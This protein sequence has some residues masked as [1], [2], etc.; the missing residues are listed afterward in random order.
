MSHS[1]PCALSA[2]SGGRFEPTRWT[3]ILRA[4]QDGAPGAAE[5]LENFARTYW[6]PIYR[7]IRWQGYKRDDAHDLTQGFY[8]HFLEK[9]LLNA[10]GERT[11][12][13]RNYLLTCLKHFLSDERDRAQA[14]K[15][16]GHLMIISREAMEAEEQAALEPADDVTPMQIFE[17]RW[18]EAIFADAMNALRAEY[19]RRGQIALFEELKELQPGKHGER[20]H[21]AIADSLKMTTQAVK[22]AALAF[23]R[24]Y[25]ECLRKQVAKTVACAGEIEQELNH[26]IQVFCR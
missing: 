15:R 1:P 13:F 18:A 26:L 11:G 3:I 9:Q 20:S 19:E 12:R 16:G 24:R 14:L 10:V 23:R 4:R 2:P 25:A 22:N 17:Q 21:A 6:P 5:A 8:A 7:F